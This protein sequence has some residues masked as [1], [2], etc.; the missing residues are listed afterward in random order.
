MWYND[1]EQ[2]KKMNGYEITGQWFPRVT[3]IVGVKS[4][5]ALEYFF[6]E[7]ETFQNAESIKKR[8]AEE[9]TL[10]HDVVENYLLGKPTP[11][12]SQAEPIVKALEAFLETHRIQL[13]PDFVERRIFSAD[14]RY[15][16][17]VD[18]LARIGG[19]FGVLDIKT[20]AGIYR[21]YNLQTSAY[22]AALKEDTV[23]D[24]LALPRDIE[25]RWILR[26]DQVKICKRCHAS[27]RE[28]GGRNKVRME[29]HNSLRTCE[30][31]EH[32]WAAPLG[33]IELK[34]FPHF[35]NDFQAF[36]AAKRLWEWEYEY[37]LKQVG[38]LNNAPFLA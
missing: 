36:L 4:K 24:L 13:H 7:V 30:V 37:L 15:A 28:K 5:P 27:L 26:I 33:V 16:G 38:Y 14:H 3:S 35:Q 19:K 9:G 32:D 25:T 2:F 21:D 23:K 22:V 18:A 11:V 34:E 17:T 1:P 8:S 29:R 6:K 20:S 10:V 12:P 31:S